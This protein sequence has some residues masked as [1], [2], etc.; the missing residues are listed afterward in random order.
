MADLTKLDA[1]A[2]RSFIDE[3]VQPFK[4]D[5]VRLR[6]SSPEQGQSL[7]DMSNASAGPFAIGPMGSDSDTAGKNLVAHTT[8]AAS[9]I[10]TVLNRH[11]TAFDQLKGNLLEVIDSM[12]KTQGETLQ[13]VEGQKFLTAIR[14]YDGAM[15]GEQ[16]T[17]LSSS[18]T[19]TA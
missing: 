9:A 4:D 17:G 7:Y 5:I 13:Q 11:S 18:P 2:L 1:P 16:S 12:L 3:E 10:D 14:E 15:T 8:Q 6:G 19:T